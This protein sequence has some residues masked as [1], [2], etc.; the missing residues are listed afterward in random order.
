MRP[1]LPSLSTVTLTVVPF[2]SASASNFLPDGTRE[3]VCRCQRS[4]EGRAGTLSRLPSRTPRT[5]G[6]EVW[7]TCPAQAVAVRPR[8]THDPAEDAA[9]DLRR[10]PRRLPRIG[11]PLLGQRGRPAWRRVG[12]RRCGGSRVL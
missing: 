8:A 10:R 6:L 5:G 2:R 12:E 1:I 11:P 3:Y 9:H 4:S 7:P